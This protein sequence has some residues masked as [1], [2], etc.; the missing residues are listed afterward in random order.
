MPPAT[1]HVLTPR[2]IEI[3]DSFDAIARRYDLT[4]RVIS[5]GVDLHWRKVAVRAFT[6]LPRGGLVLD[7]ACGTCDLTLDLLRHRPDARVLYLVTV[8]DTAE[9]E[10]EFLEAAKGQLAGAEA[11]SAAIARD[12]ERK[13][14]TLR[15]AWKTSPADAEGLP[16]MLP[17]SVAK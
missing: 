13:A 3:R 11:V 4:N 15:V 5:C 12:D 9:D 16:A 14:V 17:W 2:N 1:E 10:A 6:D 7:L 8:W